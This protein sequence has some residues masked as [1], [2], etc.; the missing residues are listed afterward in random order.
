MNKVTRTIDNILA[1]LDNIFVVGGIIVFVTSMAI[2]LNAAGYFSSYNEV[3]K[4]ESRSEF[5]NI[6]HS[7]E[8][9]SVYANHAIFEL[10]EEVLLKR[11]KSIFEDH[12]MFASEDI[13]GVTVIIKKQLGSGIDFIIHDINNELDYFKIADVFGASLIHEFQGTH[14]IF[15]KQRVYSLYKVDQTFTLQSE[16]VG[17][18]IIE[19]LRLLEKG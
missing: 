19:N 14:Y 1:F 13:C 12:S 15:T 9:N 18:V 2:F 8:D 7:N 4:I 6:F 17:I 3:V 10:Y 5:M 11:K 16:Q